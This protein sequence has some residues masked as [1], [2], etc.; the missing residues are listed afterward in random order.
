M[1]IWATDLTLVKFWNKN[2]NERSG[3]LKGRKVKEEAG[4]GKNGSTNVWARKRGAPQCCSARV[5]GHGSRGRKSA[6]KKTRSRGC[7]KEFPIKR[8]GSSRIDS[9]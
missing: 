1:E 9:N 6:P 5:E 4:F 3:M 2:P 8:R 7:R